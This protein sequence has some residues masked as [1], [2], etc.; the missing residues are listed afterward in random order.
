MYLVLQDMNTLP[1]SNSNC[2]LA[3]APKLLY[4]AKFL[5]DKIFADWPLAKKIFAVQRSQS[6]KHDDHKSSRL[7]FSRSE[8]NPRKL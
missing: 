8:V 4:G 1:L 7:K 6:T 5:W 2:C 3:K